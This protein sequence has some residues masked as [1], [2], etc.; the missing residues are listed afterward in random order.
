MECVREMKKE[1]KVRVAVVGVLGR[2]RES[3]GY[4]ELRKETNR[5]LQQEV[6]KLKVECSERDGDYGVSF[7]DLDGALP[8]RVYGRDGVHLSREGDRM[9]SRRFLE[10]ITATER[11]CR[12]R[13]GS[14]RE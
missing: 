5:M 9:M 6:L 10:W 14:R 1:K 7:L 13:E 11:L 8:P 4:E 3:R 12:M 2:P